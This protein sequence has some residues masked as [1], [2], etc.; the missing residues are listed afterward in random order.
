VL[1]VENFFI[2]PELD[3][4]SIANE[5]GKHNGGQRRGRKRIIEAWDFSRKERI[6]E[7]L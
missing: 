1:K 4:G 2:V 5:L 3:F 6:T 7:I